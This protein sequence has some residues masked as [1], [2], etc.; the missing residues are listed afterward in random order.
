MGLLAPWFLAGLAALGLPVWLHLLRQHKTTP[1]QFSSLM[2]FEPRTQSSIKHRR[3]KYIALMA[4][5]LLLLLLLVLAF[6]NPF[7]RGSSLGAAARKRLLIAAI[8]NSF[9]MRVADRLGR[10]KQQALGVLKGR[11]SADLAQV[12]TINAAVQSLT[13]P[14]AESGE[15]IAAVESIEPSHS[16]SSYG[17]FAR[18][19]RA[20]EQSN[21]MP[22]EVHLFSDMQKSSLPPAFADLNLGGNTKL[23]IHSLADKNTAN[24]TVETVTAPRSVFDPKKARVIATVAGFHTP[25]AKRTLTLLVNSKTVAS[26]TVDVP[27]NGRATAEFIGMEASYGFNRGEVR[28]DAADQL[29]ADD[30]FVFSVERSDPRSVL[31]VHEARQGRGLLYYRAALES[32]SEGAFAVEPVT[33]DQAANIGLSK[34][35]FVVLSDTGPLPPAFEQTLQKYVREGGALL[36]A[37]GPSSAGQ[38]KVPV[39][40]QPIVESRYASRA[41][42]RFLVAG[43]LDTTHPVLRA[44]GR[45]ENVKFY[46]A[47]RVEPG[48]A[49]VLARLADETP[50]LLEKRV[51][52]GRVMV[53]TST[54]DNISNDFPLRP[55]FVPFVEQSAGYLTGAEVRASSYTVDSHVELRAEKGAGTVEVLNPQGKRALSLNEA[56]SA[57]SLPL[58]E[59]GF[60]DIGRANGRHEL[61]AVNSDRKES[62]LEMAPKETIELWQGTETRPATA[63]ATGQTTAQQNANLW[64]Y[65]MLAAVLLALAE[66]LLAG[67]YLT[68]QK[69]SA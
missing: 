63:A 43:S 30:S 32:A 39:F 28:I 69:E 42:E 68:A 4:A 46:Q 23:V 60:Y 18:A 34:Y 24:W 58:T 62:D 12:L 65:V 27:E 31:F 59:G 17:E 50:L 5:R 6:A 22:L 35:G 14:T 61:V 7:I 47:I 53:F 67:N 49:K 29:A 38:R 26:K 37:L 2:F 33:V 13:Q 15:L 57:R 9:S 10:A 66:S 56:A 3:L 52:E 8:D 16:R 51:G 19:L 64:W 45:W 41:A 40:D 36:V 20:I 55:F 1:K 11:N 25:A 48:E 21:R 54:F 44:A